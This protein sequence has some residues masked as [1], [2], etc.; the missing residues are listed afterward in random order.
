MNFD[1]QVDRVLEEV[2]PLG[3]NKMGNHMFFSRRGK[4]TKVKNEQ[5][6]KIN[7]YKIKK[8]IKSSF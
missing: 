3:K 5:K 2:Y 7:T 6:Y 4:N 1:N 8:S